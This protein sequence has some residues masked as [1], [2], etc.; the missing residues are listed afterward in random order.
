MLVRT[1]PEKANPAGV[2]A[3]ANGNRRYPVVQEPVKKAP[4]CGAFFWFIFVRTVWK[5]EVFRSQADGRLD[6][7]SD[8]HISNR[9]SQDQPP[10]GGVGLKPGEGR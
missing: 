1:M 5:R 9:F 7:N 6:R 8:S 2:Y 10:D 4:L 3:R